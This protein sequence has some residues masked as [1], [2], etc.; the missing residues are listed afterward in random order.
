MTDQPV[1]AVPEPHAIRDELQRLVLADLLGPLDGE[2]E[3]FPREDPLDRYPLGRLAPRGEI[4]EPDTQDDLAESLAPESAE[5]DA[6][7]SAPNTPSLALSS[8]GFTASVAGDTTELLVTAKWARYDRIAAETEGAGPD[9]VWRRVPMGGT[10]TMPLVEGVLSPMS[11]DPELPDVVVRGRARRH[12]G[13]WLVSLFLENRQHRPPDLVARSWLFQVELSAAAPDEAGVFLPRP[14]RPSGGDRSDQREQ[15]RLAMAY[16]F[17]PEFGVGHGAAVHAERRSDTAPLAVRLS[18]RTVPSHEMPAT[19]VPSPAADPD[20]SELA[21]L[22]LDMVRLAELSARPPEHLLAVLR[23]MVTG[24]RDW[25][26]QRSADLADPALRLDGY[27]AEANDALQAARIAADRIEAGVELLGADPLARQAFGFANRAMADQ[28]VHSIVAAARRKDPSRMLADVE[29]AADEPRNRS[30][31]PF[32]LAFVLLNL[33]S[34]ADPRHA[35]RPSDIQRGVADLL[36]FPTGGGKTEAYLGL[37]AFTLAIRRLQA[38]PSAVCARDAG[39]AVLMRY[40][41]RL[42]T[43]QQFQRAAT[44]I[45]AGRGCYAE[46][47]SSD[48]GARRRFGIGLWVG[49]RVDTQ[50]HRGRRGLAQGRSSRDAAARRAGRDRRT[51]SPAARGAGPTIEQRARHRGRPDLRRTLIV[52]PEAF[53]PFGTISG[54]PDG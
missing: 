32:Q 31:R 22:V 7:P 51:S 40:T 11:P 28:R 30:W 50:P 15:Q 49:G 47:T 4:I 6:E 9:R 52:C 1:L 53:C 26:E 54:P 34:L 48:A 16:R 14:D 27:Q 46:P 3:E 43:M 29:R 23:P 33:P 35:E 17:S 44:L 42:L 2:H 25:I 20:L 13:Y 38:E 10:V 19:D 39:V 45:C 8:I 5:G 24:Y 12:D 18:T 21:N 37:T 36:W 41:L